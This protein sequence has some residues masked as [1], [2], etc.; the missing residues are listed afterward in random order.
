MKHKTKIITTT[1]VTLLLLNSC[2]NSI[3]MPLDHAKLADGYINSSTLDLGHVLVWDT[4]TNTRRD[5][6]TISPKDVPSATVVTG[7]KFP[8]KSS[9][10]SK[11]TDL[12]VSTESSVSDLVKAEAKAKFV[13]STDVAL[14]NYRRKEFQDA[15]YVLNSPEMR[16]WRE[17]LAE[18]WADPKYR[19]IFVSQIVEGDKVEL[20]KVSSG[21]GGVD[22]NIIEVGKYKFEVSYG[23]KAEALIN[24][25]GG[26]I[27]INPKV[28]RFNAEG[29]SLRFTDDLNSKFHLQQIKEG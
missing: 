21:E 27:T 1:A 15:R 19:F 5:I 10:V 26:V 17:G 9:S 22:A 12:L 23:K 14:T 3:N 20:K 13:N 7:N 16:T 18:Q 11:D 6:Y 29:A 2:K 4:E 8:L 28:Y 25:Q 24:A